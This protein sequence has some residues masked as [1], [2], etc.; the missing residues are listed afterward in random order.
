MPR[1]PGRRSPRPRSESADARASPLKRRRS[2]WIRNTSAKRVRWRRSWSSF[3][4]REMVGAV[5]A[6]MLG[7]QI[8]HLTFDELRPI[9]D[10][11]ELVLDL[12]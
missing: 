12:G 4:V 5:D 9:D 6:R 11:L 7:E 10:A 2:P 8:G 3:V 1:P